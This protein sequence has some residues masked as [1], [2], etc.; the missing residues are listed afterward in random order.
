DFSKVIDMSES[1]GVEKI[2]LPIN[3]DCPNPAVSVKIADA[4][5]KALAENSYDIASKDIPAPV[6]AQK[7]MTLIALFSAL[8]ILCAIGLIAYF[9]K[10]KKSAI[11]PIAIFLAL[12]LGFGLFFFGEEVKA[13]TRTVS[14]T[15][16]SYGGW[17]GNYS[18][19][20]YYDLDSA[21]RIYSRGATMTIS[22]S[23]DNGPCDNTAGGNMA[24][25][26]YGSLK[27][28]MNQGVSPAGGYNPDGTVI[29]SVYGYKKTS[30]T[31]TVPTTPGYYAVDFDFYHKLYNHS[32][33][34]RKSGGNTYYG[35]DD[36]NNLIPFGGQ[37]GGA[38]I[39]ISYTVIAPA[40]GGQAKT[41]AASATGWLT[42]GSTK[43]NPEAQT[44][45][46]M[47]RSPSGTIAFPAAGSSVSWTCGDAQG[48]VSCT[49]NHLA[50]ANCTRPWGGT[51]AHGSSITAYQSSS[52]VSPATCT[53]Q[54]RTC[55]NGS[56]SGSY[57]NQSCTVTPAGCTLPWGGTI[58]NGSSVT[59]YSAPSVNSPALCSSI[60]E[61]R[62]CN[63]GSLSGSYTNQNCSEL[64][65]CTLPWGGTIAN[66]SS[67]TAYSA[68]SV[69][70]PTLCSSIDETRTCNDGFLSGSYT[71][72]NCSEKARCTLPWGGTIAN[73]T[74]VT[75][76]SATSVIAPATCASIDE[77]RTCNDGSLSGAY[78]NQT[79]AARCNIPPELGGGTLAINGTIDAYQS[80]TAILPTTCASL[81]QTR[82]CLASGLSGSY[83]NPT[84][85]E[86]AISC[87]S[88]ADTTEPTKP[89][90]N[91]CSDGSTPPVTLQGGKWKWT[92][93][94]VVSCESPK[95]K[96]NFVES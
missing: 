72:Q 15:L 62:T 96:F 18:T 83:L 84:C 78:T 67:V 63:N 53:S 2:S 12:V 21:S 61:T 31:Y 6:P 3:K 35:T 77:T 91:L 29:H 76:Y 32:S 13:V 51:L 50:Y 80:S 66:G 30:N 89:K 25:N 79:C 70:L 33:W 64:A 26:V 11:P 82:T 14:F 88:A 34:L 17:E 74:S 36:G 44:V 22:G 47:Y 54:S 57:T 56:L 52:V 46:G 45:V 69:N 39:T 1:G 87:G 7:D 73:G 85:G 68:P 41:Y 8:L 40:C 5:G 19:N 59:A 38:V 27:T 9:A 71:N 65:R 86:I 49:A 10:K 55:N 58:A 43:C 42:D 20:F 95:G 37:S 94:G 24:A 23:V 4:A 93:G 60:D 28:F 81:R 48:S 16:H 90:T 75:A 92:C